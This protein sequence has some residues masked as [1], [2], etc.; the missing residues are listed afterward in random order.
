MQDKE[1]LKVKMLFPVR[2][3]YRKIR[4]VDLDYSWLFKEV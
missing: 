2:C 4:D 1:N 3:F